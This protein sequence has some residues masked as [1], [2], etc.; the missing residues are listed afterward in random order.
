MPRLGKKGELK[1][2]R[3]FPSRDRDSLRKNIHFLLAWQQFFTYFCSRKQ[4]KHYDYE[5]DLY[6]HDNGA[7]GN[8]HPQ[9]HQLR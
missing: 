6:P 5:K 3:V 7:G 8:V 2:F 4:L 1:L 9:P